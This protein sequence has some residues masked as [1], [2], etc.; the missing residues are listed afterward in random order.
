[1]LPPTGKTDVGLMKGTQREARGSRDRAGAR[2]GE[3]GSQEG[4]HQ[5]TGGRPRRREQEA[6]GS[7]PGRGRAV[8]PEGPELKLNTRLGRDRPPFS[9]APSLPLPFPLPPFF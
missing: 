3:G 5:T 1:M 4:A 9:S 7:G 2:L 8:W 6:P